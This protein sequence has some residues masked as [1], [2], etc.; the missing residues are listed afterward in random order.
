MVTA[1]KFEQLEKI[2]GEELLFV[3]GPVHFLKSD[4][5]SDECMMA[6]TAYHIFVFLGNDVRRKHA[7]WNM[8]A[9]IV[10]TSSFEV[11]V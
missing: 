8:I 10:S 6:L 3:A 7:T 2:N 4:A 11:V 5:S 1:L 9:L